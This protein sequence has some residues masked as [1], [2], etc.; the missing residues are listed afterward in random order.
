VVEYSLK[1]NENIVSG[2]GRSEIR[3]I[4]TSGGV[5][6]T[7]PH[8]G[9]DTAGLFHVELAPSFLEGQSTP[10]YAQVAVWKDGNSY[11]SGKI[12]ITEQPPERDSVPAAH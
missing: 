6:A 9:P 7:I 8:G 12:E 2:A 3:L 4:H 11:G 5:F 10:C 1:N